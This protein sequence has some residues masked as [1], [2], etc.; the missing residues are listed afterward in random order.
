MGVFSPVQPAAG[1]ARAAPVRG[2]APRAAGTDPN[3]RAHRRRRRRRGRPPRSS[4]SSSSST[5]CSSPAISGRSCGSAPPSVG[6]TPAGGAVRPRR[7]LLNTM[8]RRTLP[9]RHAPARLRASAHAVA[10]RARPAAGSATFA[11]VSAGTWRRSALRSCPGLASAPADPDGGELVDLVLVLVD[12]EVVGAGACPAGRRSVACTHGN[13]RAM[14]GYRLLELLSSGHACDTYDAWSEERQCRVIVRKG[15]VRDEGRLLRRL[16]RPNSSASTSPRDWIVLETLS[17]FTLAALPGLERDDVIGSAGSSA[18]RSATCTDGARCTSPPARRP[19]RR[20]GAAQADRLRIAQRSGPLESG[21]GTRRGGPPSG[22]RR[23]RDREDRRGGVGDAGEHEAL[24][25][26]DVAAEPRQ[27]VAEP[28]AVE[29]VGREAQQVREDA[30]AQRQQEALAEPRREQVVG[31]VEHAAEQQ[32][33]DAR[34]ADRHER[35]DVAG[36]EHLVDDEAE[37]QDLRRLDRGAG[38]D[39]E[40]A[41]RQP[42]AERAR[43]GPEAPQDLADGDLRRVGDEVAAAGRRREEAFEHRRGAGRAAP[44]GAARVP[45]G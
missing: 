20:R 16:T 27:Q 4:C 7:R 29:R 1:R 22:A 10:R 35:A 5:T 25:R 33:P 45:W 11:P 30:S 44:P 15:D 18:A 3:T 42:A 8:A 36:H 21:T 17:G 38:G 39:Q 26:G 32:Q 14:K 24:D 31:E 9:A 13:G 2:P 19:A 41:E 40:Q 28:A 37:E 43:V 34:G 23:G 12:G 6:V